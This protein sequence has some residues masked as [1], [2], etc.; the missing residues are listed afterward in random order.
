MLDR[1]WLIM[2]LRARRSSSPSTTY[3][4]VS[5]RSVPANISSLAR[6]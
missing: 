1:R 6:E 5:G 4:G 3:Q 2:V